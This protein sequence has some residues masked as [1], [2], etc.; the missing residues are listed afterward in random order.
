V[1]TFTTYADVI[2]PESFSVKMYEAGLRKTRPGLL[3]QDVLRRS[4]G[5]YEKKIRLSG[6]LRDRGVDP[7]TTYVEIGCRFDVTE[8]ESK[9]LSLG[10]KGAFDPETTVLVEDGKIYRIPRTDSDA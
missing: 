3:L 1:A 9:R 5:V 10:H 2:T 8:E 4:G 6:E 7:S